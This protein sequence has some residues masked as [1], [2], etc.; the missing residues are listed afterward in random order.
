MT[1]PVFTDNAK[2]AILEDI[3]A[4][5][6]VIKVIDASVFNSTIQDGDG[7]TYYKTHE[8]ATLSDGTNVEIVHITDADTTTNEITVLRRKEGSSRYEFS[9]G[10]KISAN[11]TAEVM[12][13]GWY[14]RDW[15]WSPADEG[16]ASVDLVTYRSDDLDQ[17]A[18]DYSIAI[19]GGPSV[20]VVATSGIAIGHE[21]RVYNF[22]SIAMGRY[23]WCDVE[24]SDAVAISTW[25]VTDSP[26][27]ISIGAYAYCAGIAKIGR[28]SI[29]GYSRAG[30]DSD[31]LIGYQAKSYADTT[32]NAIGVGRDVYIGPGATEGLALGYDIE[33][34]EPNSIGIGSHMDNKIGNSHRIS[35]LSLIAKDSSEGDHI[36][37]FSGAESVVFG[38]EINLL[39]TLGVVITINFPLNAKFFPTELGVIATNVTGEILIQPKISF[40]IPT[41]A[42]GIVAVTELAFTESGQ[43]RRF[44]S[45]VSYDGIT[46][47]VMFV[48]LAG[49]A[50]N[51]RVRPYFKGLFVENE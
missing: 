43:R 47:I 14:G 51:Y 36:H 2:T 32:A 4:Y 3:T 25:A 16:Y 21:S 28:I 27:D 31:I 40:G 11:I 10:T 49:S 24:A 17:A 1:K 30:G 33:L 35:G 12:N 44:A 29:G 37:Y 8:S 7:I 38:H 50:S 48:D 34:D 5:V 19:G 22:Q 45:L 39:G 23:A 13:G 20:L 6:T 42:D 9:A 18:A 46:S 15:M 41:H 26:M